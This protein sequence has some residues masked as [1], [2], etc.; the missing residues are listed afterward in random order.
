MYDMQI[1]LYDTNLSFFFFL[2]EFI[3]YMIIQHTKS[4]SMCFF[5]LNLKICRILRFTIRS[6]NLRSHLPSMILRMILILTTLDRKERS[7]L[8][9]PSKYQIFMS[10]KYRRE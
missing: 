4:L 9:I 5:A 1:T 3:I 6:Y 10:P 8:Y 7:F 2:D